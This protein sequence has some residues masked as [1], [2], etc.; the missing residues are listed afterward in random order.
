MLGSGVSRREYDSA[1]AAKA[2]ALQRATEGS[3]FNEVHH[4]EWSQ[5]M[6]D[7]RDTVRGMQQERGKAMRENRVR[8]YVPTK[9]Q[10][11]MRLLAPLAIL[12]LFAFNHFVWNKTRPA[13]ISASEDRRRTAA[14]QRRALEAY[15]LGR[16]S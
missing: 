9:K 15:P 13:T 6:R 12:A 10:T 3:G 2:A 8:V 7:G 11:T 5:A 16:S 1:R 4:R 14:K